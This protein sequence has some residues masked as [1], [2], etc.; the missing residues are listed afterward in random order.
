MDFLLHLLLH[1]LQLLLHV[2]ALLLLR[3]LQF[4]FPGRQF[5]GQSFA[6]LASLFKELAC[7]A[8]GVLLGLPL[9]LLRPPQRP[10][11]LLVQEGRLS[12]G[13]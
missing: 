11:G 7:F 1:L 6:G 4:G 13:C 9:R 3:G 12:A 2:M 5:P 10:F 8:Q